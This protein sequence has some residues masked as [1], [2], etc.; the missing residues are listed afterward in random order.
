MVQQIDSLET[1]PRLFQIFLYN[2]LKM[3]QML[4]N[5]L[6]GLQSAI[7]GRVI[8]A[9]NPMIFSPFCFFQLETRP[10][11]MLN[12]PLSLSPNDKGSF[13]PCFLNPVNWMEEEVVRRFNFLRVSSY[14]SK[15][16]LL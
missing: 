12:K 13:V 11:V 8:N 15:S 4:E 10:S 2:M 1:G 3:N 6:S 14:D 7:E 9:V 5:K 16:T